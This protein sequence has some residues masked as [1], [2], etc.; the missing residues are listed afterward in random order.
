MKVLITGAAGFL[1]AE[2]Q[3]HMNNM[4]IDYIATDI[5]FKENTENYL[6]V[7]FSENFN[8]Y[9]DKDITHIIHLAALQFSPNVPKKLNKQQDYFDATNVIGTKNVINFAQ[10]IGINKIIFVSTDMVYGNH[11]GTQKLTENAKLNPLGPYGN[12]K[13]KCEN[14]LCEWASH[15][16]SRTSIVLRPRFIIG[17]FRRGILT[18]LFYLI[19]KN[20]PITMIGS[21][22][23]VYQMISVSQL[24]SII[25]KLLLSNSNGH[26]VFNVGS[27]SSDDVASMLS[28][29]IQT[30]GSRSRLIE[31][32]ARLIKKTLSFFEFVR[33][34][35]MH[36]EQ[37]M[38][39][40]QTCR[41]DTT[42]IEKLLD[43]TFDSNDYE[44]IE[45]A[46]TEY[47]DEKNSNIRF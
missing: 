5:T 12:S 32:N 30:T 1:G 43:L 14:I 37:Y 29:L 3:F 28:K 2:L 25:I 7:R 8:K 19:H 26:E 21:G 22:N 41:L 6:D 47:L 20:L 40:D 46:Y 45:T 23:N 31:T 9:V 15:D 16:I 18:K 44:L 17:K 38:I 35:V 4:D 42:K 33:I 13:V 39:A 36:R 11:F 24:S 34:P 10:K 27:S